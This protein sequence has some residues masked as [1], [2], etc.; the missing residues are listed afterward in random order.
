[1][2]KAP[3]SLE[4]L[5]EAQADLEGIGEH[6]PDHAERVLEKI[7]DWEEKIGWGRVP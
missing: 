4:F 6:N 2:P 3:S 1:M 7:A 5:P